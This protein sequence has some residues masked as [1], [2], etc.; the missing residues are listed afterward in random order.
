MELRP[1]PDDET[2]DFEIL[3]TTFVFDS[4]R[5]WRHDDGGL[6]R[7]ALTFTAFCQTCRR[8]WTWQTSTLTKR[9][10]EHAIAEHGCQTFARRLGE[11]Q[12]DA[13]ARGCAEFATEA[14]N[15]S[16]GEEQARAAALRRAVERAERFARNV[17][18]HGPIDDL[19]PP[20]QAE[21]IKLYESRE[22][23][24]IAA[25]RARLR[26]MRKPGGTSR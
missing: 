17:R 6:P 18:E 7:I 9:H 25:I 10:A 13:Y 1:D 23:H 14:A 2:L 22:P 11:S 3:K 16:A 4:F 15:Q 20:V 12:I 19:S 8:Q 26:E 21:T 5:A 24:E